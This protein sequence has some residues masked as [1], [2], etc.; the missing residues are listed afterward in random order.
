MQLSGDLA[1]IVRGLQTGLCGDDPNWQAVVKA[2]GEGRIHYLLNYCRGMGI[3]S[4]PD[5]ALQLTDV[6][7]TATCVG[8]LDDDTVAALNPSTAQADTKTKKAFAMANATATAPQPAVP[9]PTT[10]TPTT[11][12]PS[13]TSPPTTSTAPPSTTSPPE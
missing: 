7:K 6:G 8:P 4:G 2:K 3:V 12:P 11:A 10:T 9:T 5:D 1:A 13:T